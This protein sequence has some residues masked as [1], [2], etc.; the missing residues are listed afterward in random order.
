MNYK[1]KLSDFLSRR[2]LWYILA[3]ALIIMLLL[4]QCDATKKAEIREKMA[5]A[6]IEALKDSVRT[7]KNKNGDLIFI[8]KALLVDKG[9]L[10]IL[11]KDLNEEVK[12]LK[13]KII[14]LQKIEGSITISEPITITNEVVKYRDGVY[15]L[16]W[17]YD[18]VYSEGNYRK[19]S[20]ETSV[21]VDSSKNIS[22][23]GTTIKQDEL[24]LTLVTGLREKNGALEIY[25]D[26]QYPGMKITR[27]DGAIIEPQKSDAIKKYFPP[28][29]W[30]IGPM[31][32]VGMSAG[33]GINGKPIFGPTVTFGIGISYGIIRF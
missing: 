31:L 22:S 3:I 10:E 14:T 28:K 27:I 33:Y 24:A 1:Q 8:K 19:F 4:R 21:L 6:N 29:K 20:G 7:E 30:S 15:G 18:T 32:G 5:N 26:P 13:G 23:K 2:D 17:N 12:K 25:V 11:N 9:N 16:A